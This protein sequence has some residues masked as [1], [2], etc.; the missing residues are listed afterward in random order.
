[1]N[2]VPTSPDAALH[3]ILLSSHGSR[4]PYEAYRSLRETAPV[5]RTKSGVVVLSRFA[6]CESALRERRLAKVDESLGFRLADVPEELS[7][8]AMWRFRRTMLFRNAPDHSRLRRLVN[9]VFT[10]R[11]VKQLDHSITHWAERLLNEADRGEVDF[12][13]SVALPLPVH[14]IGDLVGVPLEDRAAAAPLVRALMAPL[15]PASGAAELQ[16]AVDAENELA[17]YFGGL[18]DYKR[19]H[20]GR[21]LLTRIVQSRNTDALDDDEAVGTAILLFAAGFETTS[22][23]LGNGLAALLTHPDQLRK[24]RDDRSLV[25]WAVEEFL[26]FDTPVQTNGRTAIEACQ[27]GGVEIA[28]GEVVL[29]LLGAANRDPARFDHPDQLDVA[30]QGPPPLSFGSGIHFCLGAALARAEGVELFDRLLQRF[31]NLEPAGEPHW[32]P[33]LTFRGLETLPVRL[34]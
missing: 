31:P 33:G 5:L 23:L 1:M 7:R 34:R 21:D 25:P 30:R 19:T 20:P 27:I 10:P 11:H 9:D 28:I 14:V 15:E 4:G 29:M 12:M 17:D 3:E 16:R 13:E 22:N 6:D 2:D 32:R 24:L 26:R 18:L 8:R